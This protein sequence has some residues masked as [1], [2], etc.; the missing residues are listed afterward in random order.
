VIIDTNTAKMIHDSLADDLSKR[1][2]TKRLAY[3]MVDSMENLNLNYKLYLRHL[4]QSSM[5]CL[6]ENWRLND[7]PTRDPQLP[8]QQKYLGI[9]QHTPN[10]IDKERLR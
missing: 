6:D 1:V 2:F 8:T 5:Q 9:K 7:R 3:S 10:P 4:I